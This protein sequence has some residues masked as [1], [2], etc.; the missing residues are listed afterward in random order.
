MIFTSKEG[1]ILDRLSLNNQS[2]VSRMLGG[3]GA[4]GLS[5]DAALVGHMVS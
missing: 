5:S 2:A 3:R 1:A 4:N